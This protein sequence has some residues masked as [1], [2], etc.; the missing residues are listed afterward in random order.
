MTRRWQIRIKPLGSGFVFCILS[1]KNETKWNE[2]K[3]TFDTCEKSSLTILVARNIFC[4]F[5][6]GFYRVKY[7]IQRKSNTLPINAYFMSRLSLFF[8]LFD[9]YFSSTIRT[10]WG[11]CG[12]FDL[13][14]C[15]RKRRHRLFKRIFV[16]S[17]RELSRLIARAIEERGFLAATVEYKSSRKRLIDFLFRT[18]L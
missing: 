2:Q 14:A 7:E 5:I 13:L 11:T 17:L 6:Y 3:S 18:Y 4:I 15:L 10:P 16:F 9:V 1:D 12:N 8:F